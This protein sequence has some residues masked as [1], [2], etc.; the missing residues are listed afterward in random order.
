M[1]HEEVPPFEPRRF[2]LTEEEYATMMNDILTVCDARYD[3]TRP[4]ELN[5]SPFM[6]VNLN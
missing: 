6:L 2:P 1:D 3:K 5:D 4:P